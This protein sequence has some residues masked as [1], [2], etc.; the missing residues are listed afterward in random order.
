MVPR[1][2]ERRSSLSLTPSAADPAPRAE[3]TAGDAAWRP[4]EREQAGRAALAPLRL[5]TRGSAL[6]LAQAERVIGRLAAETG[7]ESRPVVIRT[8]GDAD[9]RSPLTVI[10]GRGVFTSALGDALRA[11][12]IDAAVH[13]AKDLPSEASSGLTLVAFPEREDARD[14]LVS[15]HGLPL[16]ALPARPVIG[17][18]SRRRAAQVLHA[19]PDARIVELRGNLDTRLRK[20]LDPGVGAELD[21]VVVAA[22]GL[23]RMGWE[24]RGTELLP[25]DTFVPAPGQGALAIE[26]RADDE[27]ASALFA[28]ID[29]AAVARA[30]RVER[31]FLRALGA[32]C[33]TPVGAHVALEAGRLRLRGMLA[34]ETDGT[35]AWVDEFVADDLA[36]A[37]E[38]AT[39]AALRLLRQLDPVVDRSR[40]R[41][42]GFAV[43]AASSGDAGGRDEGRPLAGVSVLVTRPSERAASLVAA[44]RRRGAEPVEWPTIRIEAAA[45]PAPLDA[46]LRELADGSGGFDWVVVTSASAVAQVLDRLAHIGLESGA[47]NRA[48]VA[49]VGPATAAALTDVGVAVDLVPADASAEGVLATLRSRIV[50]SGGGRVRV[51]FPR[52][53]VARDALPVGL[54]A[55]GVEVVDPIA[56]RTLDVD[57]TTIAPAV[58]ERVARGEIDVATFAS[59]SSV[60]NF[61][62]RLGGSLAR[63]GDAA[64]VCVGPTTAAAARAAGL[65]VR[66]VADDASVD[67]LVAGVEAAVAER[68]R[69]SDAASALHPSE[70]EQ[71]PPR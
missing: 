17:T 27:A 37:E 56:Y 44:L 19:R 14:V 45:D 5:G 59:P 15:R 2:A 38:Q 68:E 62:A 4:R 22:A 1:L 24:D 69:M 23:R 18:S 43:G 60:R 32:G 3:R 55:L 33:T 42:A 6:A 25:L 30:V 35:S 63:L 11:G 48:A 41:W 20:A 39:D 54:R 52:G 36:V 46:A 57:P 70:A 40:A 49:V 51:L 28:R 61:A 26:I 8:E 9:K 10:G 12:E 16:A 67:G 53:D 13:S 50:G 47:L 29:D 58:R 31:A 7:R 66:I 21:G 64:I 65:R 71:Q 34:A